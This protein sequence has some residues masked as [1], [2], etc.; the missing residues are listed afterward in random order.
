MKPDARPV[1]IAIVGPGKI[2]RDQHVPAINASPDFE[3]VASVAN[4]RGL[5]GYP[6]FSSVTEMVE[7]ELAGGCSCDLHPSTSSPRGGDA[8]D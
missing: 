1:K 8:G 4:Q 3:L 7:S 2:A 6:V 5:E